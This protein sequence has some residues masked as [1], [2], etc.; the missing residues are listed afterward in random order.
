[1]LNYYGCNVVE[2]GLRMVRKNGGK[3]INSKYLVK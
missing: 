3:I 2:N 1:M